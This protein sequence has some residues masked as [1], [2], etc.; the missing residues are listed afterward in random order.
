MSAL[1]S[2]IALRRMLQNYIGRLDDAIVELMNS[3]H[4][5]SMSCQF[6]KDYIIVWQDRQ[7]VFSPSTYSL[8]RQ[9]FKSPNM[10]LSKEDIRQDVLYDE[11]AR[12]GCL[13]QCVSTARKELQRASFPYRIET[14]IRKGYRLV[15][16][17]EEFVECTQQQS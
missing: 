14:I 3:K 8:L 17:T 9:F 16:E 4:N 2:K 10:T 11:E 12:E 13:R 15:S 6:C 1:P 7:H 5:V